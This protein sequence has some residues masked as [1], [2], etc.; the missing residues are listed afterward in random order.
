[1]AVAAVTMTPRSAFI[2]SFTQGMAV[3][4]GCLIM[5]TAW[6][7]LG[8]DQTLDGLDTQLARV[9]VPVTQPVTRSSPI[10]RTDSA[11]PVTPAT[12]MPALPMIAP[13]RTIAASAG[14]LPAAPVVGL[15]E[16]A[17]DG[18]LPR[19][20]AKTGLTPFKA[21]SR[22][23]TAPAGKKVVS[24]I[25][26]DLG[27]SKA[28]FE[29]AL[30]QLPPE[31]SFGLSPYAA[32][33]DAL[34]KSARGKGHEAWLVLPMQPASYPRVDPG[35]KTL[36]TGATPSFNVGRLTSLM[37]TATG[38]AGFVGSYDPVFLASPADALPVVTALWQRGLGLADTS[39]Q[40]MG[41]VDPAK[42]YIHVDL[43]IDRSV[44]ADSLADRLKLLEA[45]AQ[46]NGH[47]SAVVQ[48]LPLTYPAIAQWAA[49]LEA[50]GFA[51]GPLSAQARR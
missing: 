26:T 36:L 8:R 48:P 27:L 16:Q 15:V 31:I 17:A 33:G 3:G 38:Y 18:A 5:L 9:T 44:N 35:P 51:L 37:K 6:L 46:R 11:R 34:V 30:T 12:A 7:W 43:W 50:R 21:Y 4:G 20:D 13:V 29:S 2:R 28:A 25:V 22:P 40:A 23:F 1:M 10:V 19:I 49:G 42:P 45:L 32:Q 39:R 41:G 14:P 47:A 24:L